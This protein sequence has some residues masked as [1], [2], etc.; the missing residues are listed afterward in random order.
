MPNLVDYK[1][2][3]S[4]IHE[5]VAADGKTKEETRARVRRRLD[6]FI[7]STTTDAL[8]GDVVVSRLY[9]ALDACGLERT[10]TQRMF[11]RHFVQASLPHIYSKEVFNKYKE[12]ILRSHGVRVD[13]YNQYTLIRRG[14]RVFRGFFYV[15]SNQTLLTQTLASSKTLVNARRVDGARRRAWRSS[16]LRCFTPC[17]TRGYPFSR[18]GGARPSRWRSRRTSFCGDSPETDR[19]RRSSR[20]PRSSSSKATVPPT[21]AGCFHTRPPYRQVYKT[22]A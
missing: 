13:D 14:T 4:D 12:R 18:P 5:R 9:A 15:I 6:A 16:W 3:L 10:A 11:H 20:T 1:E 7:D 19:T 22:L 21:S 17:R 2:V 8:E